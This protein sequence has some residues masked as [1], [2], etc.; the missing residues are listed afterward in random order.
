[1]DEA[2]FEAFICDWL[3]E[4]GGYD[5]VKVGTAQGVPTDF[6][7]VR[8]LD[9]A[10]L[11]AF[12]GATQGEAWD[13]LRTL[14][15]DA[16]RAQRGFADRLVKELESRGT[17]DVLRHGVVDLGVTI[18]LAF[19]RP[20]SGLTPELVERYHKNRLTVTRQLPYEAGSTKTLDL[21]LFVNGVPVATAELK[22]PLTGQGADQAIEQYRTA[23]DP[24]NSLLRRAVV[25]FAVDTERVAMTTRLA[26]KATRFLPFNRGHDL[27]AGNPPNPS[28]HR[29]AYLWER[30]WQRDAWLDL[31]N[32]FVHVKPAKKGTV[33][34]PVVIFPR[35]HQ[36]DAVLALTA[37]AREQG[38]GRDC[39]VQ[40]SAGSGKSNTIAWLAHRLSSLHD[41]ADAR[42]FDKVVVITDRRVLDRQL[43]ETIYQFEHA[44]GVVVRIDENSQ[45]LADALA[46]EQ[47][48]IVITTL[49]K[50]PFV[51]DKIGELPERT[52]AVI[53]DEAHSSQTGDSATALKAVLGTK[54]PEP[55]DGEL[56]DPVE[57]ALAAAVAARGR[58]A[59]LSFFAFTATPKA[60]TLELFGRYD[61]A[62]D[63]HVPFH[64]Y[65]MRQAIEE[66]FILDVLANYVT[67]KTYWNIEQTT[68][69]DPE[70]DPSQARAAIARFVS[71][72]EHN[73]AQKAEVIVEHYRAKVRHKIGGMAKAMVVTSS[74][75][76]AARYK[77]ALERYINDKG[78]TD[79][80]VL[81]AFSGTLD[82]DGKDETESSMNTFPE[83]QTTVEFDTDAWHILVVAEKYQTG[84]DQPKLYAMYVDKPLTGLAAVQTLSR[85]NRTFDRDGIRKDG[86]FVLDFRNEAEDIHD[87]FEPYYGA[88]VAPPTDPNLLYDT[89]HA[90]DLY[91][92]LWP[93]EIERMVTL[94]LTT[95]KDAHRQVNA[96]LTPAVDRFHHDLDDEEQER[97]REDLNRFIRTYTFLSQVVAFTDPKLER[98]YLFCK[99]LAALIKQGGTEAVH[100]DVEL[101]H[102]K[103][104]QTFEGSVTL[105]ETTGEV[106]TIFG[107][108]RLHD[109][110]D[111]P[112]SQI[113]ARL[114]ERYGTDFSAEDRVFYDAV[115]DKLTKRADIQQ[116]AAV[117]PPENFKLVLEKEAMAGVLDQLGVAEDMALAYVDNPDM[118]ADVI[119]AYLPF[120]Q[121]RSKVRHQE[122]CDIVDLL[123]PDR[124]STH[125]EY[126]ATLRTHAEGGEVFKPLET[127]TLKTI[128]AFM[129]S[130]EGGTLLIGVADD[131]TVH[132]LD[133]DYTSRSKR[134]QDPRDWFL[135]HLANII[136]ASM[137]DAAATLVRPQIHRVNGGEVCRVQVDPAGFP[138][139]AKVIIQKPGGPKETRTEFYV[140]IINGTK[141]LNTVEREKYIQQ[142]WG[143]SEQ[144]GLGL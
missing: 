87:A 138:V 14:Y 41:E 77:L 10:E 61:P 47:A 118:Q 4:R 144:R 112:L 120:V 12:I 81:V 72:H 51:T 137:G 70:Y 22:N 74:R 99:A 46:G 122:H 76:H 32:R 37:E 69:D 54:A 8:G 126:K 90:L 35:F 110:E 15:G 131:G 98:D 71:L 140:R 63:R 53:V 26:G 56:A 21:C 66:G 133:S 49:Q 6:D 62:T 136:S 97:F 129:N 96:A 124:E 67:Y 42:V 121:G 43:Q 3:V 39:L 65:S 95:G 80:G 60:R 11:F 9:T 25:H 101:T 31:L 93:D 135:Q 2:A 82:I 109:P 84:F 119:A 107:G 91:G 85:L 27:G 18:R 116:A 36:W 143:Y 100:P 58:Q 13:Q 19:F 108:G 28:G 78:Y 24:N 75:E 5:A 38:A 83:S 7:V 68:P 113:I 89:R 16:D 102:L 40:H 92:V 134:D 88:T 34:E 86:T 125:L 64:L 20:A 117:N 73:L 44:H 132:G 48:R 103:V 94:L 104:D 45:Q 50:F 30:V 59:N 128:A 123:G 142:R 111:E 106:T 79:V 141:A 57:D 17:V 1:M 33:A 52:Y 130:R 114:N 115:F 23:R 127:A 55:G 139:D 29:T 105:A